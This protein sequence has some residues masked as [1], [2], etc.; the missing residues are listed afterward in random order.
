L[1]FYMQVWSRA[2]KEKTNKQKNQKKFQH[3]HYAVLLCLNC[4]WSSE[5][6]PVLNFAKQCLPKTKLFPQVR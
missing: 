6:F 1:I 3:T 2:V 5:C 4:V